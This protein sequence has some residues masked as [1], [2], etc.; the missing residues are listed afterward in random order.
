M[1]NHLPE[2]KLPHAPYFSQG[3]T[4]ANALLEKVRPERVDYLLLGDSLVEQWPAAMWLPYRILHLGNGGDRIENVTWRLEAVDHSVIV[5]RHIILVA[6]VNNLWS[7]DSGMLSFST[8]RA[9]LA[10]VQQTWPDVPVTVLRVAPFG[11]KLPG[12]E[13]E[14]TAFND[15]IAT[16]D[17]VVSLDVGAIFGRNAACFLPDHIHFSDRGYQLLTDHLLERL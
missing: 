9:C 3:V 6:G 16:D 11:S 1:S 10:R 17:T 12:P 5:P 15:A 4:K 13:R 14:R 7:G 8:L 2:P